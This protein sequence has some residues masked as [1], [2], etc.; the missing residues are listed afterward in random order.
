ML[1][2]QLLVGGCYYQLYMCTHTQH[3]NYYNQA[4]HDLGIQWRANYLKLF[5]CLIIQMQNSAPLEYLSTSVC[6][7]RVV[8]QSSVYKLIVQIIDSPVYTVTIQNLF[9]LYVRIQL[10]LDRK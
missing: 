10:P 4:V 6:S 3:T 1:G 2:Y 5:E 7:I 8:E 9:P